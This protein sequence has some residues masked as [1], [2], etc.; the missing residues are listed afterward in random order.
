MAQNRDTSPKTGQKRDMPFL[1][2]EQAP[3]HP[4]MEGAY[5]FEQITSDGR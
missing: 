2:N 4:K 5:D 3:F 1:I